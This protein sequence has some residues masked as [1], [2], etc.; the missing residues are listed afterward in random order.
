VD[1]PQP[2]RVAIIGG[3]GIYDIPG[4][5][6][7]ER[8]VDTVYGPA[9]VHIGRGDGDDLVFLARHGPDHRTP[10]HRINYRAN[11]KALE[12]LGVRAIA[13][14]NAVGSINREIPPRGLALLDDFLDFTSGRQQTF[15]DGGSAGVAHTVMTHPYCTALRQRLLA[16]APEFELRLH[17]RGTY[18]ATNGPRFETP[19]EIRMY[20]QMGCDVVGMTGVPEVALARELHMHYAAIAFSINWAAGIEETIIVVREGMAQI[21]QRMLALMLKALRMPLEAGSPASSPERVD[22]ERGVHMIHPPDAAAAEK[23]GDAD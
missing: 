14:A 21:R 8:V 17:P 18:A 10:P 12:M 2:A 1:G 23:G 16:L 5:E 20:E 4:V 9:L 13:A 19:A 22:C 3:T 11:L 7:E 15:Y 6:L